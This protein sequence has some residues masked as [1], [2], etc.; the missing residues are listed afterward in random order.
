MVAAFLP[1]VDHGHVM[2]RA[3][4]LDWE[5]SKG[6]AQNGGPAEKAE[7]L[8]ATF[9]GMSRHIAAVMESKTHAGV[10]PSA[11]KPKVAFTN[12]RTASSR[13]VL[14][15]KLPT[16]RAQIVEIERRGP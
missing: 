16:P 14:F 9:A 7:R 6:R 13:A 3:L 5:R 15:S 8:W 12:A 4:L 11:G 1:A 2:F 10:C